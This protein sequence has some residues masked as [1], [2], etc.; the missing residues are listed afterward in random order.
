VKVGRRQIDISNRN[1]MFFPD[2]GLTKG[3]RTAI[4][5]VL[6]SLVRDHGLCILLIEHDLDFGRLIDVNRKGPLA[7]LAE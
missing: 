2:A 7:C 4:G 5:R 6:M 1:K 3:E